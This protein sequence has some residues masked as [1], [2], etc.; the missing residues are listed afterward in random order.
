MNEHLS[1]FNEI[2][3]RG[4]DGLP[5][6]PLPKQLA[7]L[8][9]KAPYVCFSGGFGSGKTS[10]LVMKAIDVLLNPR[11]AGTKVIMSR[12]TY[13]RLEQT[14]RLEFFKMFGVDA[15]NARSSPF[16]DSWNMTKNYGRIR[17]TR[18]T[19]RFLSFDDLDQVKSENAG[20]WCL[21]EGS[22]FTYSDFLSIVSRIRH[23]KGPRQIAIATN[24]EGRNWIW[25]VFHANSQDRWKSAELFIM[26]TEENIYLPPDYIAN[27]RENYPVEWQKRYL[28]GSF[29][30]FEGLIYADFPLT[31]NVRDF[32]PSEFP[33]YWIKLA[34]IDYGFRNPTAAYC[35]VIDDT[36]NIYIFNE[37][38]I[39]GWTP[40]MHSKIF[41]PWV[42]DGYAPFL[43][44][45]SMK[46]V[47]Y[48]GISITDEYALHGIALEPA[49][50]DVRVGISRVQQWIKQRRLIIHPSCVNMIKEFQDYRWKALGPKDIGYKSEPEEPRKYNDH[51]MD[52]LRY[53]ANWI[54]MEASQKAELSE[55]E[56][57]EHNQMAKYAMMHGL[58]IDIARDVSDED[59][60]RI[61][62]AMAS[63]TKYQAWQ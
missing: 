15:D 16:I 29:D 36:G 9:S 25:K 22:E 42:N 32:N 62:N 35:A 18:S 37:H 33:N 27:M 50:N 14:T 23:P 57:W 7:F 48:N 58:P 60:E 10:T 34:G 63:A 8:R 17:H 20:L 28:D 2:C 46:K 12:K 55:F 44:D 3:F 31:E 5:S 43:C 1:A 21:D 54:Y 6:E 56:M 41:T 4:G 26:P 61:E 53:I 52:V 45:P 24:P 19:F 40:D 11:Y 30:D 38:Y 51:A 47:Q 49:P 59:R 39:S 13:P